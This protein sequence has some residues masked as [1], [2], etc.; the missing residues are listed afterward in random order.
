M[1]NKLLALLVF[2]S[3]SIFSLGPVP[4]AKADTT[5]GFIDL[6]KMS[7]V[8]ANKQFTITF[9]G[10]IDASKIDAIVIKQDNRFIPVDITY[11]TNKAYVTPVKSFG[12]GEYDFRIFLSNGKKYSLKFTASNTE[13]YTTTTS[14][15]KIIKVYPRSTS[16]FSYPYY[17]SIPS[18]LDT[19]KDI[20]LL[21]EPNNSGSLGNS[22]YQD[23]LVKKSILN[24]WTLS[25]SLSHKTNSI[26]LMPVFP[27]GV[28]V[29]GTDSPNIYTHE[30]DRD[31][32]LKNDGEKVRIDEQLVNMIAD[33]KKVLNS[34][35]IASVKDK[36][37]MVGFSASARFTNRFALLHSEM[38]QAVATGGINSEPIIPLNQ[39]EGQILT[40]PVGIGDVQS[41]TGTPVNLEAYKSV[42]Q[43]IFMGEN[44]ANDDVPFSDGYDDNERNEIYTLLGKK[45]L[46]DRW[47]K[48]QQIFSTLPYP[49]QFV[50]YKNIGHEAPYYVGDDIANFLNQNSGD[51]FTKIQPQNAY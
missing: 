51:T 31:T 46:P 32:L 48:V 41:I 16:G 29:D 40:Y 26:E 37:F 30:L 14:N 8:P 18:N 6:P 22:D 19:S 33:A 12:D 7:G 28:T 44:D 42:K 36:V 2:I 38:V 9:S 17:L 27:R 24:Q 13:D 3:M 11:D 4:I 15:D 25:Y 47:N 23:L 45:Q 34:R 5:N 21:V 39:L 49:I 35:Q 20:H 50:T 1:R 43:Y 10:N